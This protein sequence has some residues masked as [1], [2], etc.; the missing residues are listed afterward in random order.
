MQTLVHHHI[1]QKMELNLV[2][3]V[4]KGSGH[5]LLTISEISCEHVIQI[6]QA[7]NSYSTHAMR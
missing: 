7:T 1:S 6:L 4:V 5:I 3:N 2:V